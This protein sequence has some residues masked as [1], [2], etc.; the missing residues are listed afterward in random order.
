MSPP[1]TSTAI[2]HLPQI[3]CEPKTG[4]LG[5][6]LFVTSAKRKENRAA[7]PHESRPRRNMAATERENTRPL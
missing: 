7:P 2:P 5:S 4:G 1:N 6:T 3:Q